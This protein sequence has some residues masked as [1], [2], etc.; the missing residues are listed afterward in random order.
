MSYIISNG[1]AVE[2][3]HNQF[4]CRRTID[5]CRQLEH[6]GVTFL[7]LHGRT[8]TDKIKCPSNLN[9]LH[10]VKQSLSVPL[11]VNGDCKTLEDADAFH[12]Q[13]K[14]D[15]VMA[16][17]AILANPTLF[18][19]KFD[20]T[21]MQCIQEWIDIGHAASENVYFQNFHH[22]FTFM[23]EKMMKKRERVV[24]N[25]YTKK[26]Q[27]FKHFDEFYGIR[28]R[29]IDWEENI[30]CVYDDHKYQ[31]RVQ[32]IELLSKQKSISNYDENASKGNYFL[33]LTADGSNSESDDSDIIDT[34][35]M[36]R[37]DL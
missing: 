24:F 13:T 26:E 4:Y 20:T 34:S 15:G 12:N 31:Q 32:E 22:H 19:G 2:S 7:T 1:I 17:R 35:D 33:S 36:F 28:P 6:C 25:D 16:A 5:L 14:C 11:I 18:S 29:P 30:N 3:K 37:D 8:P 21:P 9:A 23:M 10:E 27:V